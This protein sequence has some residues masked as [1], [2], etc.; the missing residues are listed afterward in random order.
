MI[1]GRLAGAPGRLRP[2]AM[3]HVD[4][5]SQHLS[6]DIVFLIDTGADSTLIAPV[7]VA[8]LG[9]ETSH[10]SRGVRSAGVGG[11]T[12]TVFVESIVTLGPHSF[13]LSLRIL[14]PRTPEQQAALSH[15]PSL[16]G[17]DIL[18]HFALFLEERTGRVLLLEPEEAD[19][20]QLP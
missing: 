11:A 20:L 10:L 1:R 6:A 8:V 14:A 5:P 12:D 7:D 9:L 2:M 4:I 3:A 17:R 19:R 13:D 15:I 16:L 18:A